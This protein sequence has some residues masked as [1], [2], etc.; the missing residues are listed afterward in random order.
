MPRGRQRSEIVG[1]MQLI[2][3]LYLEHQVVLNATIIDR[4]THLSV[5]LSETQP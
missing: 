4:I 3:T 5:G 2:C 1:E